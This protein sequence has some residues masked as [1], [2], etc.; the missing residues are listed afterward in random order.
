MTLFLL[1]LAIAVL[2]VDECKCQLCFEL[3]WFY[4]CFGSS[5][6][7]VTLD[8]S[9]AV[10]QKITVKN[11]KSKQVYEILDTEIIVFNFVH[12]FN[13]NKVEDQK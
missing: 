10:W 6:K 4:F 13:Q 8:C 1:S 9:K 5:V 11:L 3:T 2:K 12:V 7:C